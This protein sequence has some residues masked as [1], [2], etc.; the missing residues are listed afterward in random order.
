MKG[1]EVGLGVGRGGDTHPA[2]QASEPVQPRRRGGLPGAGVC[3]GAESIGRIGHH[4]AGGHGVHRDQQV[5]VDGQTQRAGDAGFG[6]DRAGTGGELGRR[7]Q[8]LQPATPGQRHREVVVHQPHRRGS[9][10]HPRC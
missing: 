3:G 9:T 5:G 2:G 8:C 7:E 1:A 4:V 10:G 6:I